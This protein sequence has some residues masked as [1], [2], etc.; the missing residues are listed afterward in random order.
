M[1]SARLSLIPILILLNTI[2]AFAQKRQLERVEKA[3]FQ[4]NYQEAREELN[5]YLKKNENQQNNCFK[6]LDARCF[7]DPQSPYYNPDTAYRIMQTVIYYP[8]TFDPRT[9]VVV[10][11]SYEAC[12]DT[13]NH[14]KEQYASAILEKAIKSKRSTELKSFITA[15]PQHTTLVKKAKEIL[16]D[17]EFEHAKKEDK[18]LLYSN[19]I[20]QYPDAKQVKQAQDAMEKL[21]Y[22][23]A[24]R[25]NSVEE[26]EKFLEQYPNTSYKQDVL[27]HIEDAYWQQSVQTKDIKYYQEFLDHYPD[28][29]HR[30]QALKDIEDLR[31]QQIQQVDEIPYYRWYIRN[32]PKGLHVAEARRRIPE[33]SWTNALRTHTIEAYQS[34]I[35]EFPDH[36]NVPTAKQHIQEIE[37]FE[38]VNH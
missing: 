12:V 24:V 25:L 26:Y 7:G 33:L 34:F 3:I 28:S 18:L 17:W 14:R 19:F 29:K 11:K 4:L 21:K 31:W 32:Y 20:E 37:A 1:K 38:K 27:N 5:L 13:V 22:E 6:L 35:K 8:T 36:P 16:Q 30:E 9:D 2:C 10:C 23:R 15:Y